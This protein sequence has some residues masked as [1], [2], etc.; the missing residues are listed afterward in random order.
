MGGTLGSSVKGTH[1][2]SDNYEA[3]GFITQGK[4]GNSKYFLLEYLRDYSQLHPQEIVS[5][6]DFPEFPVVLQAMT[7]M[8]FCTE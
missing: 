1:T 7:K 2:I 6:K 5:I 4:D 8:R 3:V